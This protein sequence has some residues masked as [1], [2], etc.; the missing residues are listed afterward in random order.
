MVII[1]KTIQVHNAKLDKQTALKILIVLSAP[2]TVFKET[3]IS[4]IKDVYTKLGILSA[5]LMVWD[6]VK[7]IS[8]QLPNLETSAPTGSE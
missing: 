7:D 3:E 8:M 2:F 1:S 6:G 4:F 5:H